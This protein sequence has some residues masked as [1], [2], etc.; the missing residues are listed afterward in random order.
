MEYSQNIKVN[1]NARLVE[2]QKS[3]AKEE[4]KAKAKAF[5]GAQQPP[6]SDASFTAGAHIKGFQKVNQFNSFLVGQQEEEVNYKYVEVEDAR[7]PGISR[8]FVQ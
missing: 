5:R 8:S 4:A 1:K 6:E 3:D 2:L 7:G